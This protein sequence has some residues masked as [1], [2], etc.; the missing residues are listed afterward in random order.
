MDNTVD[1]PIHFTSGEIQHTMFYVT[2]LDVSCLAVLGHSWLTRYN[3]LIDWVLGSISFR[4]SK[5]TES[6]APP[7]LATPV[8]GTPNSVTNISFIGTATFTQASQ[9]ADMQVFKLFISTLDPRDLNTTP[10]DMSKV[11]SKYHEFCDVFS[12]SHANTLLTHQPCCDGSLWHACM[13]M[14]QDTDFI[15]FILLFFCFHL[16][17]ISNV[18]RHSPSF[19]ICDTCCFSSCER[20]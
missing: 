1:L 20:H 7:E 2:P 10:V 11:P 15:H 3:L 13:H 16:F 17:L 18:Y 8:S 5:E 14:D 4:P 9:L 19:I 12:K 6:L